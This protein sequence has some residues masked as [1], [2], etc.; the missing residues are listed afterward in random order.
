MT[1]ARHR[2][3]ALSVGEYAAISLIIRPLSRERRKTLN[4]RM[5]CDPKKLPVPLLKPTKPVDIGTDKMSYIQQDASR[6]QPK[7][8][9]SAWTEQ[10][11]R[12][13]IKLKK[14]GLRNV[15]IAKK[16]GRSYESV[17]TKLK[18]LNKQGKI[19]DEEKDI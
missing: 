12:V 10:E 16:M 18:L 6:E 11:E 5:K 17:K 3:D 4:M 2:K 1:T 13:L 14:R 19:N 7:S 9:Y 15:M 8:H